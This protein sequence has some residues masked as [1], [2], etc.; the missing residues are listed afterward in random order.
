MVSLGECNVVGRIL[1]EHI[2]RC[3]CSL[4]DFGHRMRSDYPIGRL[5]MLLA[6]KLNLFLPQK[7]KSWGV[8]VKAITPVLVSSS[9]RSR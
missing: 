7:Y 6:R 9:S 4:A 3:L 5:G 1:M 2:S 8:G